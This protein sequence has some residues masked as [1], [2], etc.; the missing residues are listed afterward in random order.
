[1]NALKSVCV[2]F[3]EKSHNLP[4]FKSILTRLDILKM[5]IDFHSHVHTG[6]SKQH[7]SCYEIWDTS[8]ASISTIMH[9]IL[10]WTIPLKQKDI[11]KEIL[12]NVGMCICVCFVH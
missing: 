9:C 8:I 7:L 10:V 11:R 4:R 2:L 12:L 3:V 5:F 6:N 1:M